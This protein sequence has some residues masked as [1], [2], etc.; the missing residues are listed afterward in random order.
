MI[1]FF[2]SLP[3]QAGRWVQCIPCHACYFHWQLS[4]SQQEEEEEEEK[5]DQ[6]FQGI[7]QIG[8]TEG[9]GESEWIEWEWSECD[10]HSTRCTVED[11]G[12]ID[13]DRQDAEVKKKRKQIDWL[14]GIIVTEVSVSIAIARNTFS[15]RSTTGWI[16]SIA[17][18]TGFAERSNVTLRTWAR[19]NPGGTLTESRLSSWVKSKVIKIPGASIAISVSSSNFDSSKI[20]QDG[21][22]IFRH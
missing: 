22:E 8:Q 4:S 3:A 14:T 10:Y 17:G 20:G 11:A 1:I 12:V 7:Q 18:R 21:D 5:Q 19:F 15:E 13:I 16:V 6:V 9:E 2:L